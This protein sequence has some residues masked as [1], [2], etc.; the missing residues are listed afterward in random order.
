M[1]DIKFTNPPADPTLKDVLDLHGQNI[2]QSINCHAIAQIQSFDSEKQTVTATIMYSKTVFTKNSDNEYVPE[3]KPYP[4][5]V[6]VPVIIL[7]GNKANLTMPITKGDECLILFN[8]RDIDNWF[9]GNK[10]GPV[11]SSRLHSIS[12]GFALI[13]IG[14]NVSSYDGDRAVIKNDKAMIA[15]GTSK[16][17]ISNDTR[18]LFTILDGL[19]TQLNTLLSTMATA[20]PANVATSVAAPSATAQAQIATLKTHLGE[21]LE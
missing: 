19:L 7:G 18:N 4:I 14:R 3:Q 8:D 12:D 1:A 5:L 17:E 13:G 9:N 15:V 10:S 2:M 11:N 21:L 16:I 20:T 6:D